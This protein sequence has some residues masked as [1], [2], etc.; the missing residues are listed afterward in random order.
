MPNRENEG[1]QVKSNKAGKWEY[2]LILKSNI[3]LQKIE[4][5]FV[6]F[7]LEQKRLNF[8]SDFDIMDLK[9]RKFSTYF[10]F[11]PKISSQPAKNGRI[12][13]HCLNCKIF[14]NV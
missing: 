9:S 5:H 4:E 6:I 2:K 8:L 13:G 1:F 11:E 7:F 12:S 14:V 10:A 3:E